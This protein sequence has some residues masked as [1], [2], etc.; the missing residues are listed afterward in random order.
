M[1][2][3][4][5]TKAIEI[6]FES[7]RKPLF[8]FVYRMVTHRQ[9]AEDLTQEVYVRALRGLTDYRGDSQFKTWLFGIATHT[10]LDFLREKQ[11]WRVEAQK[12]AEEEG[13]KSSAH[14]QRLSQLMSDPGFIFE[15]KEHIAYCLACIGRTLPPE[16]QAA[17]L[18][19]DMFGFT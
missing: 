15:I 1:Q 2:E 8:S 6:L 16:E 19:R 10:C 12:I 11:R 3:S 17:I 9:D 7:L 5:D 4:T 18:L 13:M 14:N